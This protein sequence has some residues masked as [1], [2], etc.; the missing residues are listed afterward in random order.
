MYATPPG[1]LKVEDIPPGC[2]LWEVYSDARSK[3]SSVVVVKKAV[4]NKMAP[5]LPAQVV[6]AMFYR[7]S[8]YER[9]GLL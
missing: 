1:L 4:V 6:T 3:S 9:G 2:G 7:V 8:N 5:P